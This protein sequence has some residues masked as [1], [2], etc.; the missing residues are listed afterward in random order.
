LT[1]SDVG[2][3]LEDWKTLILRYLCDPSAK[4]DKSVRQ[5]AFKYVLHNDELYRRT[6]EG[7]LLKCLGFDQARVAIGEIHEGICDTHQSA[8]KTKWL[9]RRAD[10]YWPT[11]MVDCF[12]YYKGCED[13]QKFGNIQL[14][15]AAMLH[16]IIKSW[17]FRG[18][19]LY[20]IG[21]IHPPSS[22]VH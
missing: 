4:V 1:S 12:R 2:A 14:V 9:L 6:I 3:D 8:P 20:F 21:H 11:M 10:F 18:G 17:P 13:C 16:P 15:S 7:L 22:K 5:S 19:G